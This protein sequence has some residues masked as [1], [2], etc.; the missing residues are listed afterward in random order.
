MSLFKELKAF[1][2]KGSMIDLAVAVVIG[3]AFGKVVSAI[4]GRSCQVGIGAASPPPR[5]SSRSAIFSARP[6]TS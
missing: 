4:V 5:S 2:L 6:S 3:G 1:A